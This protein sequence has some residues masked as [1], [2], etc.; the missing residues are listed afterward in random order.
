VLLDF[1][2]VGPLTRSVADAALIEGVLKGPDRRDPVSRGSFAAP[3][4]RTEKKKILF[5][6]HFGDAPCDQRII[7][8]VAGVARRFVDLGH[9]VDEGALPF[10]VDQL[11]EVWPKIP[12]SGLAWL[13]RKWP[14]MSALS[15]PKYLA[16]AD[17]G[18]RLSAI[19]LLD[20]L[21]IVKTLRRAA[22]SSFER[23][24]FI[25]TPASAAMPWLAE[26][27]FPEA[28]AGTPVGPRGHAVYT[29]W[30][31]AA[32]LPAFAA[33]AATPENGLPIGFQLVGDLGSEDLLF[34][35]AR[36]YEHAEPWV[37][38]WPPSAYSDAKSAH[39]SASPDA[40]RKDRKE[41]SSLP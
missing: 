12:Q 17:A 7:D 37:D 14:E 30:V 39:I 21:E 22:S 4:G 2:V 26:N 28:I 29:G 16:M 23:I 34:E 8:A 32:G 41:E 31:N 9:E 38:R 11:A 25:L 3:G 40:D 10:D 18:E 6:P 36:D 27:A 15:H 35:L 5:V 1:E 33:P 13:R 20:V 24:D 19:E